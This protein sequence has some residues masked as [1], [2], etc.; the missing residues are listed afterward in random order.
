MPDLTKWRVLV[1]EDNETI[2]KELVDA[3]E[4]P[5]WL[6]PSTEFDANWVASF[7]DALAM[8]ARSRF[9]VLVLDLRDDV[10]PAK[11]GEEQAKP[12]LD[13]LAEV[14][15]TRF[16][17]VVF[18]TA[19][20]EQ[21]SSLASPIVR[22]VEK[23]EG[24]VR[25]REELAGLLRT[26]L[27]RLSR[28]LEE[29]QRRYFWEFVETKWAGDASVQS[30]DL[31]Y[32]MA[33]RLAAALRAE[34]SRLASSVIAG[35][36]VVPGKEHQAHPMEYYIFPPVERFWSAGDIIRRKGET[37]YYV[38]MTPTCDFAQ[39]KAT[40]FLA[41]K[42]SPLTSF[43]EYA[44]WLGEQTPPVFDGNPD[45][46]VGLMADRRGDR[47]KFLPGTHEFPDLVVDLQQLNSVPVTD[48]AQ[49]ERIASMD[50]PYAETLLARFGRFYSRI[51]TPDLDIELA[52]AR[53][54]DRAQLQ[55]AP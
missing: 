9:D 8:L 50:S 42:C 28:Y 22:V 44:T 54:K 43:G 49:Y 53:A 5:G 11:T 27:P 12:G 40:F 52:K 34:F 23:T 46:I 33:R 51:G 41:A 1:V 30:V 13:I 15:K 2:G 39:K 4:T 16:V 18:Y 19:L 3:L 29:E 35:L 36:E 47:F 10:T 7:Q 26:G 14:K 45:R 48:Q 17:P 38:V 55:G 31:A 25:V 6:D 37:A 20:P 24:I 21:V 32:L